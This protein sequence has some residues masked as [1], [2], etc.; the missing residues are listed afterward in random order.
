MKTT[1][2]F[3]ILGGSALLVSIAAHQSMAQRPARRRALGRTCSAGSGQ[4]REPESVDEPA[5][6]S[7]GHNEQPSSQRQP[8]R[9]YPATQ[10]RPTRW[11]STA[12]R[13]RRWHGYSTAERRSARRNSATQS[14]PTRWAST[15]ERGKRRRGHSATEHRSARWRSATQRRPTRWRSAAERG[16]RRRGHSATERRSA[17]WHSAAQ[18]RQSDGSFKRLPQRI[19]RQSGSEQH[20]VQSAPRRDGTP[21]FD[22][23]HN[24]A[25]RHPATA[26]GSR[27]GATNPPPAAL[28]GR[29]NVSVGAGAGANVNITGGGNTTNNVNNVKVGGGNT[30]NVNVGNVNAG[31]RVNYSN[32]SQAWVSQRQTW[33]NDVRTG[34][35]PRYNNVFNDSYFRRG[36]VV[37]GYNYYGGWA[38]RGPYYAWSPSDLGVVRHLL[39][40][41]PRRARTGVLRL[42]PGR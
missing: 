33:G 30:T 1:T 28:P 5:G 8:A 36:P 26:T 3:A 35:G 34:V 11:S 40:R 13:G 42:R 6:R 21:R 31:N 19:P 4:Q 16:R 37:G 29:N 12:Q 41:D 23:R 17:R 14:R 27:R 2:K 39:R 9:W 7:R 15:S 10:C 38:A 20:P 32:N 24:P 22:S 25:R 18:R